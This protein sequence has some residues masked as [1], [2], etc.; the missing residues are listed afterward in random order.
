VILKN[1]H[2]DYVSFGHD[3][4]TAYLMMEATEALG[5]HNDRKTMRI[6]K[7][8]VDHALQNGWDNKVGGF[9]DDGYYF[10]NSTSITIIKD[11]KNWWAQAEGLN[12][13]LIMS[14]LYPADKMKYL[15]RFK[16]LW[17][18]VQNYLIDHEH[19]DWYAGGLDKEPGQKTA[20][21]AHIWKGTYHNFRSLSNCINRLK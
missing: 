15:D 3:V 20:L 16:Q 1:N 2:I 18:Y 17:Q 9:Y 7:K 8:M 14:D 12:T 11:T 5:N 6:G 19:G 4:E 10:K 13:L 21:K